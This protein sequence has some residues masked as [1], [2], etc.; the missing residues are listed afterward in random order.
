MLERQKRKIIAAVTPSLEPGETVQ[1]V[2]IGQT[3]VPQLFYFLIAP[4]V[5][6][7]I[8][9]FKTF[10]ATDRNLYVF[11]NA[12]LRTYKY[13]GEPYKVPLGQAR[14]E[15]GSMWIRADDGPKVWAPPFGPV[16]RGMVEVRDAVARAQGAPAS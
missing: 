5:L 2:F 3:R 13:A 9:Q 11:P 4:L 12:W 6:V 14:V 8:V 10:V 16:K 7:F 1:A 15:S